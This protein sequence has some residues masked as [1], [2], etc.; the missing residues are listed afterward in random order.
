MACPHVS[1]V[2]ALG[3]SY[4]VRLRKHFTAEEF[5]KLLY[6]T[7]TP[8]DEYMTGDKQYKRYV[9]DLELSAPMQKL[10]LRPFKGGM[11]HGQVNAYALLKAIEGAG[12]DMT[13]PNIYVQEG[14]QV[15]VL[16]SI[17]MDGDTFT[18]SVADNSIATASIVDGRMVIKGIKAGQTEAS[19]TGTRTDRFVITVREGANGNGWL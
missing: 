17:Y 19:V 8:I 3:L 14:G 12:V 18:V 10:D 5:K 13:F 16:P 1:G 11:G 2:A 15:T 9:A 4:A 7:A 6:E